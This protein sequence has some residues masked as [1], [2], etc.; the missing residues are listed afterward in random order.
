LKIDRVDVVKA[1]DSEETKAK[2]AMPGKPA[3]LIE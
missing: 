3:I 1:E 2:Q